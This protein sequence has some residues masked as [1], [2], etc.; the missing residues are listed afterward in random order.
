MAIAFAGNTIPGFHGPLD[1]AKPM[2]QTK[3][4]KFAGVWGESEIVLGSGGRAVTCEIWL[5]SPAFGSSQALANFLAWLDVLVGVHGDLVETGSVSRTFA[6]CTFEGFVN[7]GPMRPAI[8][9]GLSQ[10]S[11]LIPGTLHFYQLEIA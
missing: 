1:A 7:S 8:G 2:L 10:A 5:N 6:G 9:A 11:W 3:R 4:T